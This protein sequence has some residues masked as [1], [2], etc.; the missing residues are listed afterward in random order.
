MYNIVQKGTFIQLNT[1]AKDDKESINLK[2][3]VI[4]IIDGIMKIF[5]DSIRDRNYRIAGAG[6]L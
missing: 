2:Y 4:I 5:P 1:F 3:I 6:R